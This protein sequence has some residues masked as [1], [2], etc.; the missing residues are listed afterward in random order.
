[1]SFRVLDWNYAFDPATG[2]TASSSATGFEV[3][4]LSKHLR[5][6]VWR[7]SG[8]FVIS[9]S[10]KYIDFNEGSGEVNATLTEGSYTPD[11]LATEIK[12]SLEAVGGDTYTVSYG[13]STGKWTISS[14]GS[15]LSLLWN[16]GT[17]TA[18]SLA[19]SI[20]FYGSADSTGSLTYTSDEIA[21]HT[22]EFVQ[23]DLGTWGANP[24][25]SFI[26]FF[27]K[28][29]GSNL[30]NSAVV[31]LQAHQTQD[32][33]SPS[34]NQTLTYS[35][36][37]QTYSHFFSSA[38]NYRFWR[39]S[40]IDPQNTDLYVEIPLVVLAYSNQSISQSPEVGFKESIKDTS[41]AFMSTYGDEYF[42]VYPNVNMISYQWAHLTEAA[43]KEFRLIYER[44]G[45][46]TPIT[47]VLDDQEALFA[48][49]E[50]HFHYGRI[51]G[52]YVASQSA[53]TYYNFSLSLVESI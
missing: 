14:D 12:A 50:E 26:V 3:T 25:D 32:F 46:V 48:D 41:S 47:V 29:D 40:I 23:F 10:N 52:D 5:S 38:Q 36:D 28:L 20:G 33:S 8:Y 39:I 27:D 35:N 49:V 42:D 4:N 17:N 13:T 43:K 15:T 18:N 51:S 6:K 45:K 24:I 2:I 22:E 9:S 30:S 37:F 19:S 7:S 44:V 21:I 53:L 1:M 31:K 34:V 11:E 16:S